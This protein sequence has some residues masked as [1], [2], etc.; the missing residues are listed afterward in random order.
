MGLCDN[1]TNLERK[2]R[3]AGLIA[4]YNRTKTAL[5][6]TSGRYARRDLGKHLIRVEREINR[7][8]REGLK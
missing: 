8:L 1:M 5:E 7:T 3:L 4:D 2:E 6:R